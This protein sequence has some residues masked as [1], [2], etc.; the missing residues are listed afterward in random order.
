MMRGL[1]D[2]SKNATSIN[3][4]S[5]SLLPV[6]FNLPNVLYA[7]LFEDIGIEFTNKQE[8][9]LEALRFSYN[10]LIRMQQKY[11]PIE[12]RLR[13]EMLKNNDSS[14][15]AEYEELQANRL[16]ANSHFKGLVVAMSDLMD[17]EQFTK[18]LEYCNLPM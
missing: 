3:A 15:K 18:L 11:A 2:T 17:K 14:L 10:A 1:V 8:D 13:F 6:P 7:L 4:S 12:Q 16:Q 5:Y 9:L